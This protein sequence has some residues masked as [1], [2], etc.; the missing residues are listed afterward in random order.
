MTEK[1]LRSLGKTDLLNIMR[2]QEEE[3]ERLGAE[4][5][6]LSERLAQRALIMEDAGS[7][8]E[9]SLRIG[10][11]MQAAQESASIYLESLRL[12]Q[13]ESKQRIAEKENEANRRAEELLRAAEERAAARETLEK[14]TVEELW[15]DFRSRVDQFVR[16]HTELDDMIRG[17]PIFAPISPPGDG[18]AGGKDSDG[19]DSDTGSDRGGDRGGESGGGEA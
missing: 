11:V 18:D 7:I 1:Q 19:K 8:A 13:S 16:A 10:G 2:M 15:R 5:R 12:M 17:N 4:N 14:Q 9:A 6:A 3:I